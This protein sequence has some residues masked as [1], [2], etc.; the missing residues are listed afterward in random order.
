[1]TDRQLLLLFTR[2]P[3][4]GRA[5]TRLI[6][7]L[8]ARGAAQ[9]QRSMTEL[10]AGHALRLADS[11]GVLPIVYYC[12]GS[13]EQMVA[14]LGP[15]FE[16]R[17]QSSGDI[18]QRMAQAF[19]DN[20]TDKVSTIVVV[21]SDIPSLTDRLLI[22]A[23]QALEGREVVLGPTVDGGYYLIGMHRRVL[24]RLLPPVFADINWSTATVFT[25]TVAILDSLKVSLATL[26]TL[27]DIDRPEDLT[28]DIL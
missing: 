24:D 11:R 19:L 27:R 12:G 16:Y 14:W 13:H 22:E 5:K 21:G 3:L 1:M 10:V 4:A 26:P 17:Q 6:P 7:V 9:L 15:G 18:G 20:F 23:F 25:E 2:Y 8:G 28:A